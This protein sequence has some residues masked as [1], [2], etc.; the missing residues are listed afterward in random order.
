MILPIYRERASA[1]AEY[2]AEVA[3]V[4]RLL[5]C[6]ETDESFRARL[7]EDPESAARERGLLADASATRP[8]WDWD[9]DRTQP[10]APVVARYRAF[11]SEKFAHR[12]ELR[13][14][15]K[16][17]S[18]HFHAWR[19]RQMFRTNSQLGVAKAHGIVHPLA[20][21]ELSKG[22][23]VGCWFC[24]VSAP[25]L[26]D[27][28]PYSEANRD[29]WRQVCQVWREE[30]G[31][32][33]EQAFLY[34]AT[35]PLDNPDYEHF[36][37]DF[38]ELC[39]YFPQT[40]TAIPHR[41]F[42]R[43]RRLLRLSEE[44]GCLLN[45]FSILTPGILQRVHASFTAEELAFVELV[46]QMPKETTSKAVA[47]RARER[48]L[49]RGETDLQPSTIAC[50]S[51][52]LVQMVERTIKLIT[53]CPASSRWP[54]GYV[55]HGERSFSDGESFRSALRSLMTDKIMPPT[56]SA[57]PRVALRGDLSW[58]VTEV[59]LT[60]S[61]HFLRQTFRGL[62]H[63]SLQK[64]GQLISGEGLPAT[65]L[66]LQMQPEDLAS[67]FFVVNQMLSQGV[68]EEERWLKS[69]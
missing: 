67:V 3:H 62:S 27:N 65:E 49:Q 20:A 9:F 23:S 14:A 60:V 53:P 15:S 4:K 7:Q 37:C 13:R 47:G 39:G 29:L 48:A 51:G 69:G 58:E 50:I 5:E 19:L 35:D 40:T 44:R 28:L 25:K 42:E 36:A 38:H 55:V 24:G 21:F 43:T 30:I 22:C 6:W 41:D 45:R 12:D 54:L 68:L 2:V 31:E 57:L 26:G 56:A 16:P 11:V 17:N 1:T 61:S 63:D 10:V 66:A 33:A 52:F 18:A 32:A 8:L 46:M 59:G 64:L 34:W